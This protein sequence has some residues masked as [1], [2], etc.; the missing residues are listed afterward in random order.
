[1]GKTFL[2]TLIIKSWHIIR[3]SA[4]TLVTP[5]FTVC[6]SKRFNVRV[7]SFL[8]ITAYRAAILSYCLN[9]CLSAQSRLTLAELY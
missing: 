4:L 6:C 1:M 8:V 7:F 9:F 2:I 3:S 5:V